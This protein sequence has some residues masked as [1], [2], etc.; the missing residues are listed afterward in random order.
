[1][2]LSARVPKVFWAEATTIVLDSLLVL[3]CLTILDCP[4]LIC[5]FYSR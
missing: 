1:L 5:N 3:D 2:L 4:L